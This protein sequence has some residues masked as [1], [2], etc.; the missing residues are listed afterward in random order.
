MQKQ[1]PQTVECH[2]KLQRL[3]CSLQ[4]DVILCDKT[5]FQVVFK[6]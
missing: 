4:F 1:V 5:H 2:A 3:S 6:A